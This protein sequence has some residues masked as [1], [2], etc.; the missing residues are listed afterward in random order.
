MAAIVNCISAELKNDVIVFEK[1]KSGEILTLGCQWLVG[2]LS[3]HKRSHKNCV[4]FRKKI[5]LSRPKNM[6]LGKSKL[7]VVPSKEQF[8]GPY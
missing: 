3:N 5:S 4:G 6:G 2:D 8:V 1:L 7:F